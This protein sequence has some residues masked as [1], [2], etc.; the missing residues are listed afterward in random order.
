M[1]SEDLS[2]Y[3]IK[4]EWA[5]RLVEDEDNIKKGCFTNDRERILFSKE[6]RRLSGKT[7]VFV[8]GF[9]D[10]C[11]TRLTHT[12]EVAQIATT[13]SKSLGL[14]VELTEAIALGHD[15]GHTPFGHVGERFLN[16]LMNGC[17]NVRN[18]NIDLPNVEKGFKHNWQSLRVVNSLEKYNKT[19][20]EGINLTN[21]TQWGILNHT[22]LESTKCPYMYILGDKE[23][24][25]YMQKNDLCPNGGEFSRNFYSQYEKN[26]NDKYDWSYE[27]FVVDK[28]DEI[29]QRHHDIED[30]IEA[31][32][33]TKEGLIKKINEIFY[34]YLTDKDNYLV[35]EIKKEDDK[36]YYMPL[37]S[38]FI[39][40][41]LIKRII[42]NSK[43]NL[44]ELKNNISK[45]D[46]CEFFYN[47]RQ[48]I[49]LDTERKRIN[50]DDE[51]SN[52]EKRL[53]H[54]L[55][56]IIINSHLAQKMDGKS[57]FLLRQLLKAYV[58]NPQQL[59]DGTINT[60]FMNLNK[61]IESIKDTDTIKYNN[62]TDTL[63]KLEIQT[64]N[65][66]N[67][68]IGQLRIVLVNLHKSD[69]KIYKYTLLRTICDY[70]AGMTDSYAIKQYEALYG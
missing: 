40:S 62:V 30:G 24:C 15:V 53:H 6:F 16:L 18:F 20:P 14:N 64:S 52:A 25:G 54:Y 38:R 3:A 33:L 7:Q 68:E 27:A 65:L 21:F 8:V 44:M 34:G 13:I 67:C 29:A 28:A 5:T 57:D 22:K 46:N 4:E 23:I 26:I 47:F 9:D 10:H 50:F 19:F 61:N 70:I 49:S 63:K 11:R 12:L 2:F 42:G 17:Y 32:L 66:K 45:K 60:L 58:T 43:K 55:Y 37:I 56:G 69:L 39:I 36:N 31:K 51:F 1:C 41:M 48:E 35:E 59:P